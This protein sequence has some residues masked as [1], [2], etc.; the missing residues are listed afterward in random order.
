[1]LDAWLDGCMAIWLRGHAALTLVDFPKVRGAIQGFIGAL[2]GNQLSDFQIYF[3]ICYGIFE[4]SWF[5]LR[6]KWPV[7]A[8]GCIPILC[9]H[10]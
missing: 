7:K 9:G 8:W 2:K 10:F 3:W 5:I 1:M 6:L 4:I